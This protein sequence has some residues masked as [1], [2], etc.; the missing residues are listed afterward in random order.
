MLGTVGGP[1][2]T[3]GALAGMLVALTTPTVGVVMLLSLLP[4]KL[5]GVGLAGAAGAVVGKRVARSG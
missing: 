2:A 4:F 3:M 1:G 5:L